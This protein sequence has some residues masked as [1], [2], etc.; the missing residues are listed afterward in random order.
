MREALALILG[1]LLGSIPTA[2]LMA[3][4]YGSQDLV[5]QGLNVGGLTVFRHVSAAAGIS[6]I[7]IDLAK[8]A[9]AVIVARYF[10]GLDPGFVLL[11]GL[12]A[13]IGHDY[14]V[15]LK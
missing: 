4:R 15:W 12:A 8:G 14:M 13:V 5:A 1:Y 11:A 10:F 7:A 9:M 3:R 6:T 2:Y